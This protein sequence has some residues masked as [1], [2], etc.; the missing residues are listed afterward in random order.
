MF[1]IGD[2]IIY[3]EHGVCHID[4]I[5]KKTYFGVTKDYYA[6]HP[7][8]KSKLKIYTPVDND[9]VTMSEIVN[10]E[11]AKEILESF[12]FPGVKWIRMLNDRY[13]TY[14]SVI[15]EGNRK[16]IAE[17]ANTL[18]RQKHK[19]ELNGV[20]FHE[21]D[22]RLLTFIQDTLFTELA[23]S[24]NTTFEAIYG[25]AVDLINQNKVVNDDC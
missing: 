21:K 14:S 7:I 4:G 19:A 1:K 24:L 8:K 3:A 25:K 15:K 10:K 12:K 6:L 16:E 22:G 17:I 5:C 23:I 2:L 9:K 20:K 18:M 13:K 11:E